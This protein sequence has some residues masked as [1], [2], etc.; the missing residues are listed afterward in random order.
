MYIC[1]LKTLMTIYIA[2]VMSNKRIETDF[3]GRNHVQL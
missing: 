3:A 2:Y 1:V